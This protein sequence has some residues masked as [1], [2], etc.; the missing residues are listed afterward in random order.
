MVDK[1]NSEDSPTNIRESNEIGWSSEGSGE[2]SVPQTFAEIMFSNKPS[3]NSNNTAT[4]NSNNQIE[5]VVDV[6]ANLDEKLSLSHFHQ[7]VIKSDI[8]VQ[9]VPSKIIPEGSNTVNRW[10]ELHVAYFNQK[11]LVKNQK[12]MTN[13]TKKMMLD[14]I[15]Y[16][17][18]IKPRESATKS[19]RARLWWRW[20]MEKIK[21]NR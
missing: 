11:E 1:F 2:D 4:N 6:S 17:H 20:A 18:P 3:T 19:E 12:V 5:S 14:V 21:A 16:M 13:R 9:N 15:K 7:Q 8:T 10:S